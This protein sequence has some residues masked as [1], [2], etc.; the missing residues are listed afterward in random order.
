MPRMTD[1]RRLSDKNGVGFS[2]SARKSEC[3]TELNEAEH[4]VIK[5][6]EKVIEVGRS[7]EPVTNYLRPLPAGRLDYRRYR[8]RA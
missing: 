3:D 6:S 7:Y 8:F 1:R 5:V 2:S 4:K